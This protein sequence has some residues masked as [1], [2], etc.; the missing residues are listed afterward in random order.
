MKIFFRSEG[1]L[2]IFSDKGKENSLPETCSKIIANRMFSDRRKMTPKEVWN[3]R[4]KG[5]V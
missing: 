2:K 1:K 3:I 4:N 5:G